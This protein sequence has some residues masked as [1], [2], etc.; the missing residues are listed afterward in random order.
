M[1][2]SIDPILGLLL[3]T[4]SPL[5]MSWPA[6]F[7]ANFLKVASLFDIPTAWHAPG[8]FLGGETTEPAITQSSLAWQARLGKLVLVI[9]AGGVTA[10]T[11]GAGYLY[12][13]FPYTF[14]N[15]GGMY[16]QIQL[17]QINGF[18]PS[19]A[20]CS[21]LMWRGTPGTKRAHLISS[22]GMTSADELI[23]NVNAGFNYRFQGFYWTDDPLP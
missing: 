11:G 3:D 8:C 16:S 18:A 2:D 4:P 12:Q 13:S 23:T 17:S 21:S 1:A 14:A 20:N 19:V 9:G 10:R 5:N 15:V 7:Q 6:D 22:N